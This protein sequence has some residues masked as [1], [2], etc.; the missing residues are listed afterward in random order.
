MFLDLD[1]VIGYLEEKGSVIV[2]ITDNL[3]KPN[4]EEC[5]LMAFRDKCTEATIKFGI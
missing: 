1:I 5:N 3:L 2:K 4:H